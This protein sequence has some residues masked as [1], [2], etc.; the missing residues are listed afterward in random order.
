MHRALL[1]PLLLAPLTASLPSHLPAHRT[2]SQTSPCPLPVWIASDLEWHNSTHNLD[3]DPRT[4]SRGYNGTDTRP[5]S[6][7][8]LCSTGLSRQ[9]P[10]YGPPDTFSVNITN[11]GPCRQSNPGS[12]PPRNIGKGWIR[13]ASSAPVLYFEGDS[14]NRN[15]TGLFRVSQQFTCPDSADEDGDEQVK[16]YTA[17]GEVMFGLRC[18][19]DAERNATCTSE[20]KTFRIPVTGFREG[21]ARTV[22]GEPVWW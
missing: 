3:C 19:H 2:P 7:W 21:V 8:L 14:N 10:G 4:L 12:V 1:L 13:C 22:G 9:P 5:S 6:N 15:G 16:L 20:A 17:H 11:V 18:A